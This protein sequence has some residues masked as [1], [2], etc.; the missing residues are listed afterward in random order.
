MRQRPQD[1]P[2]PAQQ[3]RQHRHQDRD[4]QRDAGRDP[5]HHRQRA[6]QG[7]Q[8]RQQGQQRAGGEMAQ[9]VHI[10]AEQREHVPALPRVVPSEG[11]RLQVPIRLRARI[12]HQPARYC[13]QLHGHDV[14]Q[15][16]LGDDQAEQ[17][18]QQVAEALCGDQATGQHAAQPGLRERGQALQEHQHQGHAQDRQPRPQQPP[19]PGLRRCR[20][21]L[22]RF[23][24]HARSPTLATPFPGDP[25][26]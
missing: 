13:L 2:D 14:A 10:A 25:Q 4:R 8:Q 17:Q 22:R 18:P 9:P 20:R 7:D 3:H 16:L 12:R 21:R 23:T 5:Q 26:A 15:G 1:A 6:Q 11:E 19:Q 24:R